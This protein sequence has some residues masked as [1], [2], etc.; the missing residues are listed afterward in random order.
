HCSPLLRVAV[1]GRHACPAS[2]CR[3][4]RHHPDFACWEPTADGRAITRALAEGPESVL[5]RRDVLY[6]VATSSK[7]AQ[8]PLLRVSDGDVAGASTIRR[9][10][11]RD[12]RVAPKAC[13]AEAGT[14]ATH[15]GRPRARPGKHAAD[16][17]H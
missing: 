12:R 13:I 14:G 3:T 6:E 5:T 2:R 1:G 11:E 17:T 4:D 16:A 15:K 8:T 9:S 10:I 7:L